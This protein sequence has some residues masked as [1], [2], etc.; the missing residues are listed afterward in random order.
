MIKW[1]R[2]EIPRRHILMYILSVM[3]YPQVFGW[4]LLTYIFLQPLTPMTMVILYIIQDI[5]VYLMG[6]Y[7]EKNDRT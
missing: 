3:I 2:W 5:T 1:I 6:E 7:Q 4:L